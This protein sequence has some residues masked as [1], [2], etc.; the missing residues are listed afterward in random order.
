MGAESEVRF[1]RLGDEIRALAF[2]ARVLVLAEIGVW[3]AVEG[4]L[5]DAG[6]IVGYQFVAQHVAFVDNSPQGF[7]LR[8]PIHSHRIAQAAREYAHGA[9]VRI[10]LQDGRTARIF[11][12]DALLVDVRRRTDRDEELIPLGAGNDVSGVVAA[13]RQVQ[14]FLG[15]PSD[16]RLAGAVGEH[17]DRV[18]IANV[19]PRSD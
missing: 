7:A 8:F 17:H 10:D 12:V 13:R 19:E 11:F 4:A 1:D 15:A 16:A 9:A 18:G 2:F 5:A 3:P 14:Y 6:K